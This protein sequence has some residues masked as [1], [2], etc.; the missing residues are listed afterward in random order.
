[1]SKDTDPMRIRLERIGEDGL[2]LD[3][4]VSRDWLLAALGADAVLKPEK[5]GRVIVHLE[6]AEDVVHVRGHAEVALAGPCARCLEPVRLPVRAALEVAMFPRGHEPQPDPDGTLEDDDLGVS[7]YDN[8]EI[9]LASVV[10][11]GVF[12]A[13]PMVVVCKESCLGLC[14][15]CGKNLNEGPCTCEKPADPRFAALAALRGKV[16]AN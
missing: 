14:P 6:K 11:D 16:K 9:D 1:M 15:S 5:D 2:D 3:E 4:K 13:L 8:K 10:H 12:L 7:T